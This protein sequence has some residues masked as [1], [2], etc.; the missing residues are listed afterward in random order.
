MAHDSVD[1][2]ANAVRRLNDAE[3]AA[4]RDWFDRYAAERW[5]QQI[6]RD[7][8]EGRLDGLADRAR[9]SRP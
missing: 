5:D 7:A 2:L 9:R 3:F 1:K 6:E 4:F 8:R